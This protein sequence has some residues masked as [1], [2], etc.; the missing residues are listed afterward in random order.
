MHFVK[1]MALGADGVAISNS[2]M[3]SIGC[4]AVRICNTNNC[5][6]GIATQKADLRQRLNVEKSSVQL[7]NFF[8]SSILLMQV[9]ARA[10]GHDALRKFIQEDLATWHRDMAL[11]SGINYSGMMRHP[12]KLLT[13]SATWKRVFR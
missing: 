4:V 7:K 12:V 11:L 13:P 5:P 1:A 6:A 8:E 2:A 10:C 3:Q 9:M